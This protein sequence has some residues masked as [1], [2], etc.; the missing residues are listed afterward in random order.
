MKKKLLLITLLLILGIKLVGAEE[1][2]RRGD[3]N[4]SSSRDFYLDC[5]AGLIPGC[6]TIEKFGGN[7]DIDDADGYQTVWAGGPT[8]GDIDITATAQTFSIYSS[9]DVDTSDDIGC[10]AWAFIGV[11]ENWELTT[12]IVVSA[13]E[14]V[15]NTTGEFRFFNRVAC[16]SAGSSRTNVGNV[17]VF[18]DVNGSTIAY[19]LAG[20]GTT[21][22]LVF[23]VPSGKTGFIVGARLNGVKT[24]GAS[25]VIRARGYRHTSSGLTTVTDR[26]DFDTGVQNSL[27]GP[28]FTVTPIPEKTI[29]EVRADSGAADTIVYGRLYIV[30]LDN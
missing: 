20:I 21:E 3:V 28:Q 9:S 17:N 14:E 25:P 30:F 5:S 13:G 26:E 18:G 19:V 27:Q 11:D 12:E 15:A 29:F 7:Q 8:V 10:R 4:I 16:A 6:S 23:V 1:V 2:R 22:Q 24:S